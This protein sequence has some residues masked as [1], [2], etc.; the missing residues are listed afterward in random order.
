MPVVFVNPSLLVLFKDAFDSRTGETEKIT[1]VVKES[2]Q[3]AEKEDA[4]LDAIQEHEEAD[5]VGQM[6]ECHLRFK[7]FDRMYHGLS[8]F[9]VL[10][11]TSETFELIIVS[12]LDCRGEGTSRLE[13]LHL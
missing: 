12:F 2:D 7:I 6:I 5:T 10:G 9:V 11:E 13:V 3:G 1:P 8:L 4:E